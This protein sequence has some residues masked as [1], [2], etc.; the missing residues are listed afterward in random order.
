MSI[1]DKV[2]QAEEVEAFEDKHKE[3][4]RKDTLKMLELAE[5]WDGVYPQMDG[6]IGNKQKGKDNERI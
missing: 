2:I 4:W 6:V 1:S 3:Q 5:Q